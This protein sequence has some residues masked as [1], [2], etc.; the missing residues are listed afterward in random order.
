MNN[1]KYRFKRFSSS[2][3][4][5]SSSPLPTH[6]LYKMPSKT[7]AAASAPPTHP[8]Q[9]QQSPTGI[10]SKISVTLLFVL[11]L[12]VSSLATAW[13][14]FPHTRYTL[15]SRAYDL[16]NEIDSDFDPASYQDLDFNKSCPQ[17]LPLAPPKANLDQFYT[18]EFRN[19]SLN[20]LQTTVRIPTESFD[21]LKEVGKDPRWDIFF[22]F[23]KTL[24]KLFPLIHES[25]KLEH[26]NTHGLIYTWE[27]T[28]SSL[29]P[30]LFMAHQD[31]VP[32]L[33]SSK[34]LWKYD[35]YEAVYDGFKVWGRGTS[36]DKGSLVA[37]M[38]AVETLLKENGKDFKPRRTIV[39]AF[40]FDE[41]ISGEH[42]AAQMGKHLEA[43]YGPNSFYSIIDEGG[44]G[45][46]RQKGVNFALPGVSE[47]GMYDVE[48]VLSTKG[49]HSSLPPDHT[50]IGIMAQLATL[51]EETPFLP[52]LSK[53]S[54]IYSFLQCV[55]TYSDQIPFEFKKAIRH[56]GTN[57]LANK[58][59][60]KFLSKKRQSKYMIQTSEA[61]DIIEG[62]LKVNA[63]PE[64]VRLVAN[65]RISVDGSVEATRQK[66]IENVLEI[67]ER[68][69][70][71]VFVNKT[72]IIRSATVG[73]EDELRFSVSKLRE[74]KI[75][76]N[77]RFDVND[78]GKYVEPAPL[79]P[80]N[81]E[82]WEVF[83]GSIKHVFETFA[84]PILDPFT[85]IDTPPVSSKDYN[86]KENGPVIVAP[87][88]MLANTDTKHYW[89]LSKNIYRFSP[90][91]LFD[92]TMNN[93]HTVDEF[94][95]LDVYIEA[96]AFYYTY[97]LNL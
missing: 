37:M 71:S 96:I 81:D 1:S 45:V 53:T 5:P 89:N 39:F 55:A 48:V 54:P 83:A 57:A 13:I 9:Q 36:D 10:L 47:K 41:E 15:I 31:V 40:G 85:M 25:L 84:G 17:V 67:A 60:V 70:L 14:Y 78:F 6:S 97:I 44:M 56:A 93:I 87:A 29:K 19:W 18:D 80:A 20:A 59:V 63:L 50:G 79:S 94:I 4:F 38:E 92:K 24:V 74:S 27:G 90:A 73:E 35:P 26:V 33:P 86:S 23:E 95:P 51:M 61:I 2:S 77:G 75:P 7:D 8:I 65:H 68:F 3:S 49:G 52:K 11:G 66:V 16:L 91:R 32:V 30:S 21:D 46:V 12:I 22:E 64:K 34:Y 28:D 76:G 72:E 58:L 62:G 43:K 82:S 69:D 88:L 42:G